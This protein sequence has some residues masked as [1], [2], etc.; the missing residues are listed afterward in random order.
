MFSRL[1]LQAFRFL[2]R[3]CIVF[4]LVFATTGIV[5]APADVA[6]IGTH[7][8]SAAASV[9]GDDYPWDNATDCSKQF[10]RYSWC[11]KGTDTSPLRFGFR[12]CTDYAGYQINKQMGGSISKIK[13]SWA[14][15]NY[16]GVGRAAAWKAGADGKWDVNN[17][18]KLGSVAWWD[19]RVGGGYG[20]VAIVVA[21]TYNSN[22]S[23]KSIRINEYN[24]G[25]DGKFGARDIAAGSSSW[26]HGFIHIADVAD[27]PEAPPPPP[28]PK[29]QPF[30]GDFDG[31][32]Y[33]DIGLRRVATGEIYIKYGPSFSR[34][35]IYEWAYGIRYEIFAG[36]FNGD[37]IADLALRRTAEGTIYIRYG[38]APNFGSQFIHQWAGGENFQ[39]L[40]AD[41]NADGIDDLALRKVSTGMWYIRHG[42]DF[43]SQITAE[44]TQGTGIGLEPFAGDFNNDGRGDIG[45]RRITTGMWY[46]RY[47]GSFNVQETYTWAGTA[48]FQPLAADFNK[49]GI[50]DIVLRKIS[51]GMW[52]IQM[53]PGP[54]FGPQVT[55]DWAGG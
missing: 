5:P 45:L 54:D 49:D 7:S 37:H 41:F 36:D 33:G 30:T 47:G 22:N 14:S 9:G 25:G 48:N 3:T 20:H 26:P 53:G 10:G 2:W 39:P 17:T 21:V 19:D 11:L 13:F 34:Q 16:N 23:V 15:I 44:W 29:F 55:Y 50:D 4:G 43:D 18:P 8:A 52:Y 32:G 42:P 40:A 38:P 12:N 51:T 1:R 46:F 31:D 6:V 35:T 27:S 24:H 28:D